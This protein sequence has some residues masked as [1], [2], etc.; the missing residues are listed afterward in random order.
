MHFLP[1]G[2]HRGREDYERR[3]TGRPRRRARAARLLQ[4]A[5][6][7]VLSA[8]VSPTPARRDCSS[9]K[10]AGRPRS[11]TRRSWAAGA[12]RLHA[13]ADRPVRLHRWPHRGSVR[14][15][16]ARGLRPGQG[17]LDGGLRRV[18]AARIASA[19][20]TRPE[21]IHNRYPHDY[22]CT[23]CAHRARARAPGDTPPAL[24]LDRAARCASIVWGG[25]PTTVWGFDG[26]ASAV[27]SGTHDRDE[28]R[29]PLGRRH[30][31]L[32]HVQSGAAADPRAAASLD[33]VRRG[34]GGHAH[35]AQ[36]DGVPALRAPAGVRPR[37]ARPYG[38]ATPNCTP[39]STPTS[40]PP[41][42]ATA[43]RAC[44]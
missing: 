26:L 14:A 18:H 43:A 20:G 24:R 25:D 22:H 40:W 34:V 11:P 15:A 6:V 9:A 33:R 38:A 16:R 7:R 32:Q 4:P 10:R 31:R 35:Q 3:R 19:D 23:I 36:R 44:R 30:R 13:R 2:A 42:P 37:V 27:A 21:R 17:R 12:R 5:P 39:S 41:T 28:R 8:A 1:C 29:G